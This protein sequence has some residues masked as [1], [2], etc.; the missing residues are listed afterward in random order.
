MYRCHQD[1]MFVIYFIINC[2]LLCISSILRNLVFL[3]EGQDTGLV[4]L[5]IPSESFLHYDF[6]FITVTEKE[7][8]RGKSRKENF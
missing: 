5:A 6:L 4:I 8:R 1:R 7:L 2:P 3:T